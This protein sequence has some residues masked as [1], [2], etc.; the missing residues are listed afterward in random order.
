VNPFE[1]PSFLLQATYAL[2][3][4]RYHEDQDQYSFFFFQLR[5]EKV[6]EKDLV[7]ISM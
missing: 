6:E 1:N 4:V 5:V 7:R 2:Y 3:I